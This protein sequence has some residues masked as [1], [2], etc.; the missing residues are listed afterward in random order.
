MMPA[1]E[2]TS[3]GTPICSKAL[4]GTPSASDHSLAFS[5]K[6]CTNVSGSALWARSRREI[7]RSLST[8]SFALATSASSRP[9]LA[10]STRLSGSERKVR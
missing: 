1:C 3:R 9:T 8:G 5:M 7:A 4:A 10:L 6:P 2:R